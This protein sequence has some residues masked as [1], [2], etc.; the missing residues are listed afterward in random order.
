MYLRY[1]DMDV[2]HYK[3]MLMTWLLHAANNLLA[4]W[5]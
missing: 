5:S 2:S 4:V 3:A 1:M